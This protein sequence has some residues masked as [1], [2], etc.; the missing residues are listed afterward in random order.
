MSKKIGGNMFG[1]GEIVRRSYA[2]LTSRGEGGSG[3]G[4]KTRRKRAKRAPV[5]TPFAVKVKRRWQSAKVKLYSKLNSYGEY[6]QFPLG[7]YVDV[8]I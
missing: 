3:E 7:M 5:D 1:A 4:A 6:E 2:L 8:Y